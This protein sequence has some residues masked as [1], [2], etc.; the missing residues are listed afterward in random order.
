MY[1]SPLPT[2][3][4]D[5]G[6]N[7]A[8]AP[9]MTLQFVTTWVRVLLFSWGMIQISRVLVIG[10]R[11]KVLHLVGCCTK[12]DIYYHMVFFITM[13]NFWMTLLMNK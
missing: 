7:C 8:V 4:E 11:L 1:W 9:L 6:V 2:L 13:V 5:S 12:Y 10:K 3:Y